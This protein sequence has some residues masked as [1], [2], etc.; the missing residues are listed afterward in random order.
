MIQ[1]HHHA[2][3]VCHE[4]GRIEPLLIEDLVARLARDA[5]PDPMEIEPWV[6]EIMV[7]SVICHFQEELQRPQV[8]LKEFM[9]VTRTLLKSL[10]QE[11]IR[12][13]QHAFQL[14]LLET[15]RRCGTGFELE[16]FSEIRRFFARSAAGSS[17]CN[18]SGPFSLA[19]EEEEKRERTL[20]ITGLRHCAK[21]LSG[22]SRW[23]KRCAEVRDEIVAFIR[24][25]ATRMSSGK[26][27]FAIRS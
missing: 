12:K 25:E 7:E 16:F 10:S 20:C 5:E 23:G 2:L 3:M 4:N 8:S 22:R 17:G 15:A 19:G 14:D 21:F 6:L 18:P 11:V 1:L 27:I 13:N 26:V 9:D 24:E